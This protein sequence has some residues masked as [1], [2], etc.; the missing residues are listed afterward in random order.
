MALHNDLGKWGEDI[1]CQKLIKEGYAI[2]ERNWRKGHYEIDIIAMKDNAVIFAE[3]KTRSDL[4][5]DPFE[6]IDKRKINNM[7]R[8]AEAYIQMNQL[9]HF[10][11]FD[12]FGI[13]GTPDNYRLE[14]I[15]DAIVPPLKTY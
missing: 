6:A 14:H 3:V 4:N 15:P 1:A 7:V 5:A 9:H 13:N 10:I 11:R 2:V 12:I 8:S